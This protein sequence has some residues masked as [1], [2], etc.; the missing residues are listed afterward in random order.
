MVLR[1]WL[2]AKSL[3]RGTADKTKPP[4]CIFVLE[5]HRGAN[6]AKCLSRLSTS[7]L[8]LALVIGHALFDWDKVITC[9]LFRHCPLQSSACGLCKVS[10]FFL[11]KFFL[12]ILLVP[13]YVKYECIRN[14]FRSAFVGGENNF[15]ISQ[16]FLSS[17]EG[18]EVHFQPC[19]MNFKLHSLTQQLDELLRSEND[20]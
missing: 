14:G 6:Q 2:Q 18:S 10:F 7:T 15:P 11:K 8:D 5:S 4:H 19:C 3:P 16:G 20:W 17:S 1:L 13:L 12:Q 9:Y